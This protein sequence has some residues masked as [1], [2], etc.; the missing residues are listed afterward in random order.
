MATTSRMN[1]TIE[2]TYK[3]IEALCEM[4]VKGKDTS[5]TK[6]REQMKSYGYAGRKDQQMKNHY[7]WGRK[8]KVLDHPLSLIGVGLDAMNDRWK[9]IMPNYPS[10]AG[11]RIKL[12]RNPYKLQYLFFGL[13]ATGRMN[14]A[15][16]MSFIPRVTS[17]MKSIRLDSNEGI[18]DSD[19]TEQ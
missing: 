8:I 12:V 14:F 17:K 7:V 11:Y 10:Y 19:E 9:D 15:P 16:R 3:F 18:G 13:S 4:K 6:M 2:E 1:W 5:Y